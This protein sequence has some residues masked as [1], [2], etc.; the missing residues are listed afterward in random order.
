MKAL[1]HEG[2]KAEIAQGFKESGNECV[3]EKKWTDAREYYTKGI[4]VIHDKDE[5]KW[6]EPEDVEEER[7]KR[8]ILIEQLLVN[9]ARCNL[10]MS[11]YEMCS[12]VAC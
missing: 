12:N 4:A 7:K 10:E 11:R 8:A 2:T 3:L 5:T 9:R 1:Q 6:E